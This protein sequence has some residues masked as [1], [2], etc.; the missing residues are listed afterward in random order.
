MRPRLSATVSTHAESP[1]QKS[2]ESRFRAISCSTLNGVRGRTVPCSAQVQP[3]EHLLLQFHPEPARLAGAF[4]RRPAPYPDLFHLPKGQSFSTCQLPK[5]HSF[6][7][8]ERRSRLY[9]L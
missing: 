6:F 1:S 8:R 9:A 5:A 3:S 4:H 2:S 7:G